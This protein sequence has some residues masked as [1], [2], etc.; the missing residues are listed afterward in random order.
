MTTVASEHPFQVTNLTPEN[1]FQPQFPDSAGVISWVHIGDL[2]LIHA[3]EQS[4]DDLVQI[5]DEVNRAFAESIS[6][7]YLPGDLAENADPAAYALVRAQ[8]DRLRAP[9]CAIPGDLDLQRNR[10]EQSLTNFQQAISQQTDFAFT[11]GA[12]RFI[13]ITAFAASNPPLFSITTEQREA[14]TFQCK[15]ATDNG[16]ALVL[17]MHC[18]PSELHDGGPELRKIIRQFNVKLIDMGHTHDNEIANDGHTLYATTRSIGQNDKGSVGYSIV[19]IDGGV[20]S[21][22]FVELGQLPIVVITSPSDDRLLTQSSPTSSGSFRIRAKFFGP[23]DPV[24]AYAHLDGIDYSMDRIEGSQV[25]ETIVSHPPT[26][27]N[28]LIVSIQDAS[29]AIASDE[30]N[31][32]GTNEKL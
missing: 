2:H 5:V 14:L 12:V 15:T 6:F 23:A 18:Y 11:V 9:W 22:R 21:W 25:F 32:L 8:L 3:D 20:V 26:D 31:I 17:L 4:H 24:R 7:V 29:G 13:A 28:A 19:N 16:L 27:S 10:P 1:R 30:I